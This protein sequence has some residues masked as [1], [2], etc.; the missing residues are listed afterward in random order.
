MVDNKTTHMRTFFAERETVRICLPHMQIFV[1]TDRK[2][3]TW[4]KIVGT[5]VTNIL[6][7]PLTH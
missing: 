2:Y 7:I 5:H 1:T 6:Q 3:Q 4:T